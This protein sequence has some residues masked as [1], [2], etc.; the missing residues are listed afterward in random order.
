[1]SRQDPAPPVAPTAGRP[2]V[3]LIGFCVLA[4]VIGGLAALGLE[5]LVEGARRLLLEGLGRTR[6]PAPGSLDPELSV[7]AGWARLWIP[8]ATTLGGL[9]SGWLVFRFAPE[10]AGHGTD[11]AIGAYHRQGGQVRAR[12]P[13]VKALSSAV[14]IGSGGVAGKEGPAAQ[15]SVGLGTVLGRWAGLR[16]GERRVI[17]LASM[18]AGL[19]AVFQAPLGMAIFSV[20]V[21]YAGMVFES[22][23]LIYTVIS[24]VTGYAVYGMVEGWSPIFAIPAGVGAYEPRA[25]LVFALLGLLAGVAAAVLPGLFYGI[26]R[27]FD[28]MPGPRALKPAVGGLAVGLLGMAVPEVLGSGYG[29]VELAM[30]GKLSLMTVGLLL[31]LKAPAMAL[32]IGSGGSG[33]IFAPTVTLGGLLGAGLGLALGGWFPDLGLQPGALV[34]VGMAAVFGGAARTPI[35]TLIM[36]AE[37]TGGYALI[38]P[39][40]L[41]NMLSFLVQRTLTAHSREPTL[42]E[43]QVETREDSPLHRSVF[44]RRALALI[45]DEELPEGLHPADLR[46]PRLVNLLRFGEPIPV[47][48]KDGLLAAVTIEEGSPLAGRTIADALGL[49]AGLVAVALL[50]EGA[51]EV[52]RG[53]SRMHAGDQLLVVTDRAALEELRRAAGG[54]AG[55]LER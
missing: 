47:A 55:S 10:A 24:A 20:E 40:M 3:R 39:A 36:V 7:P 15:I 11:A 14:I 1:M 44:V 22:E 28:R 42:Y 12:V 26:Q 38:V 43:A 13:L 48:G 32:T 2:P 17:M 53:P 52:P 30:A 29:W 5:G 4:G 49:R 27:L 41:A 16:G 25:L 50:R 35:S 21:L 8:A 18:A 51:L 6:L 19:A 37:M 46:L 33:G 45:D 31:L 9:L 54:A 23:A 34:I